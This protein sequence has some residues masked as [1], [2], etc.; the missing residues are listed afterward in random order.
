MYRWKILDLP[1][2][3]DIGSNSQPLEIRSL[4]Y[5]ILKVVISNLNIAK[6]QRDKRRG[7]ADHGLQFPLPI[8][9]EANVDEA[10]QGEIREPSEALG[11][12][13][14]EAALEVE[15]G[16]LAAGEDGGVEGVVLH[17][18][19]AVVPEREGEGLDPLGGEEGEP[20]VDVGDRVRADPPGAELADAAGVARQDGA[21]GVGARAA[22]PVVAE[23]GGGLPPVDPG[24]GGS[25]GAD[26]VAEGEAGDDVLEELPRE[27][28]Q[29]RPHRRR[30]R[31]PLRR[32]RRQAWFAARWRGLH[33]G[34]RGEAE[35]P[36]RWSARRLKPPPPDEMGAEGDVEMR[37]G[38]ISKAVVQLWWGG[39][40]ERT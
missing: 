24:A 8:L 6:L 28:F 35:S 25:G 23:V 9:R 1:S 30:S 3:I 32:R 7:H 4:N 21:D 40:T 38:P 26:G 37:R 34:L 5:P 2:V 36:S 27:G 39:A 10:Q 11:R 29:A 15:A 18:D 31:I 13:G 12:G 19:I 14:E 17:I 33:F 20:L 16:E 22:G